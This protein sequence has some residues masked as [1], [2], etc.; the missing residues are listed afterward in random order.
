M[1]SFQGVNPPNVTRRKQSMGRIPIIPWGGFPIIRWGGCPSVH[2]DNAH[3][4]MGRTPH[5]FMGI[6]TISP[7]GECP[8]VHGEDAYQS[9]ERTLH[10]SIGRTP[11]QSMGRIPHQS[12]TYS[13]ACWESVQDKANWKSLYRAACPFLC[14]VLRHAWGFSPHLSNAFVLWGTSYHVSDGR[15]REVA[16]G[17]CIA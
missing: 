4:S 14:L 8:S 15:M 13:S 17:H 10:Q 1:L 7:W 16:S 5:Q 9:I 6:M 12:S 3:Q 11:H 2:G